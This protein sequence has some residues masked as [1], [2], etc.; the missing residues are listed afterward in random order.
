MKNNKLTKPEEKFMTDIAFSL[1]NYY[2]KMMSE[3]MKRVWQERKAKS[4]KL[5]TNT[6]CPVNN[7]K[8]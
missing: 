1:N 2:T 7:S 8:V 5:Q 4:V 6:I 3:R